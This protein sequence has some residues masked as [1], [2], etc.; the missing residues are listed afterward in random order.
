MIMHI[1]TEISLGNLNSSFSFL[2]ATC[3]EQLKL[4][5]FV[6]RCQDFMEPE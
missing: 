6:Q 4:A 1:E 3:F 5:K 2:A